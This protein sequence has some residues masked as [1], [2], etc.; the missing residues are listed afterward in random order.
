[1]AFVT[2]IMNLCGFEMKEEMR[3]FQTIIFNDLSEGHQQS[4]TDVFIYDVSV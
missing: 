3:L 4:K 1:M 2:V